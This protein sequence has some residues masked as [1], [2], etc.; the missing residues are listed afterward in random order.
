M[1]HR[2][3]NFVKLPRQLFRHLAPALA[4]AGLLLA[5][6]A[7]Q[8]QTS[9]IPFG[10]YSMGGPVYDLTLGDLNGDGALDMVAAVQFGYVAIRLGTGTGTF[11]PMAS[12]TV[13]YY[14]GYA[15]TSDVNGDGKLDVIVRYIDAFNSTNRSIG[16][17]LGTG[18]GALA[19]IVTY[20]LPQ[21]Y[22][23]GGTAVGDLNGDGKA[24]L[25]LGGNNSLG[26][27]LSNGDGTFGVM[28][29]NPSLGST[30]GVTVG[31]VNNDGKLDVLSSGQVW[32]GNGNGTLQPAIASGSG[33][34]VLGDFNNDG[35]VDIININS[36]SFAIGLGKGDGTFGPWQT[37][38]ANSAVRDMVVADLNGDGKLDIATANGGGGTSTYGNSMGIRLGKGDGTLAMG[39]SIV[40]PGIPLSITAGDAT[41]DGRP[42]VFIGIV[43]GVVVV[44]SGAGI[45]SSNTPA[46]LT[47]ASVSVY[48][49][50]AHHSVTL[51]LPAVPGAAQA[52]VELYNLLGQ[53]VRQTTVALPAAGTRTTL[54]VGNLPT[55]MYMLRVQAGSETI[56]KQ[57]VVE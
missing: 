26:V 38:P 45:V 15:K 25:V 5:P 24:D 50:P 36:G 54:D 55:G 35:K 6:D 56:T 51:H 29:S 14:C 47:P 39:T 11:G 13:G 30:G 28:T 53:A 17:L 19:P 40:V 18:T 12:T 3:L 31:D 23:D 8:A 46:R 42:E 37:F 21:E 43:G 33:G 9:S 41:G 52:H 49:N 1:L 20:N 44:P 57:L 7:A 4:G 10:E 48:P 27:L 2:Y 32:L 22:K 34:G 16:V